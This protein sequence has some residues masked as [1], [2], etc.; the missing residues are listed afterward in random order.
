LGKSKRLCLPDRREGGAAMTIKID[1]AMVTVV[2]IAIAY[3]AAIMI[4]WV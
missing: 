2:V 1:Q 4:G 3:S